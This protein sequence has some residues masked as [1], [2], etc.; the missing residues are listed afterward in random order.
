MRLDRA[1][2]RVAFVRTFI[3][4]Q[5]I[6]VFKTRCEQGEGYSCRY[7]TIPCKKAESGILVPMSRI[8]LGFS[9]YNAAMLRANTAYWSLLDSD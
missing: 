9:I 7:F 4:G 2:L 8:R 1:L 5:S 3:S 6:L